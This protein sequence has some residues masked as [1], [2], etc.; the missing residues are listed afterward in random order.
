MKS[1][2]INFLIR[3][4]LSARAGKFL[5][6]LLRMDIRLQFANLAIL[7]DMAKSLCHPLTF[8]YRAKG[9]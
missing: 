1:N 5:D 6:T 2:D 3:Q 9:K 4:A 8:F 7:R